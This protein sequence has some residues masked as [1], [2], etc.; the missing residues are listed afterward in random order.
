MIWEKWSFRKVHTYMKHLIYHKSK[1]F[2]FSEKERMF[3]TGQKKKLA[4]KRKEN[5]DTFNHKIKKNY[6]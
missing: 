2:L 4:N 5:T 6:S 1:Y 3:K